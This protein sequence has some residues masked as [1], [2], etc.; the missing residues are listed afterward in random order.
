MLLIFSYH[1]IQ[2]MR[3][4]DDEH[5]YTYIILTLLLMLSSDIDTHVHIHQMH[6]FDNNYYSHFKAT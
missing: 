5:T 4:S 6:V 3:I 1:N 2:T